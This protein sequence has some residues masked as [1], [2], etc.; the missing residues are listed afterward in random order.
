[1]LADC[2][3]LKSRE[4]GFMVAVGRRQPRE[5][6]LSRKALLLLPFRLLHLHCRHT[7][8]HHDVPNRRMQ[9]SNQFSVEAAKTT[10]QKPATM[11]GGC[12]FTLANLPSKNTLTTTQQRLLTRRDLNGQQQPPW[13]PTLGAATYNSHPEWWLIVVCG[14]AGSEAPWQPWDNDGYHGRWGLV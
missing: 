8:Y 4:W 10:D 12:V 5:I 2:C 9:R 13:C 7:S 6:A 11:V 1:M 3:M 14:G